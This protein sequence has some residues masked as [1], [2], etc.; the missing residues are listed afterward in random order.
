MVHA[1][2]V[3]YMLCQ[4]GRNAHSGVMNKDS[5]AQTRDL[6]EMCQF[7]KMGLLGGISPLQIPHLYVIYTIG[8]T[9]FLC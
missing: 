2:G 8:I 3:E 5:C 1:S 6:G 4:G 9:T 7:R